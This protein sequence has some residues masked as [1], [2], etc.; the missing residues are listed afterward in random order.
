M[1]LDEAV[2]EL[3]RGMSHGFSK[4]DAFEKVIIV[5]SKGDERLCKVAIESIWPEDNSTGTSA[6]AVF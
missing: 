6:M 2:E 4:R 5:A 1:G 3:M